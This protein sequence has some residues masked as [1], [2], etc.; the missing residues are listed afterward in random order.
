MRGS[1]RKAEPLGGELTV[2]VYT[3]DS[4]TLLRARVS[5]AVLVEKF[6]SGTNHP[7]ASPACLYMR[8]RDSIQW[9]MIRMGFSRADHR[10]SDP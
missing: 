2:S 8:R 10:T 7:S 6:G 4:E 3:Y 1:N 5:R 9:T